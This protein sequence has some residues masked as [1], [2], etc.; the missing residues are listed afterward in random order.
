[1]ASQQ[2]ELNQIEQKALE[3]LRGFMDAAFPTSPNPESYRRLLDLLE[4]SYHDLNINQSLFGSLYCTRLNNERYFSLLT[5]ACIAYIEQ[6]NT[7]HEVFRNTDKMRGGMIG[8]FLTLLAE[9][10]INPAIRE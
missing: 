10:R 3:R 7:S 5:Q 9:Q 4:K 6:T 2:A 1:M 8:G